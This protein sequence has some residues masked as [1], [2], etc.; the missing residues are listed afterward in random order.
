[1]SDNPKLWSTDKLLAWKPRARH[2]T[3]QE[4]LAV[5]KELHVR[6][7]RIQ[8]HITKLDA[9]RN[10]VLRLKAVRPITG[11]HRKA[12]EPNKAK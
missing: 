10:R 1:M 6:A 4:Y 11:E 9:L 5:R 7:S 3:E 12:I 8:R 2:T